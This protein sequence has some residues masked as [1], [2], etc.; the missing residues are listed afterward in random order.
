[1][2]RLLPLLLCAGAACAAADTPGPTYAG[3]QLQ[4][5][6]DYREWIWLTSGFDMSY[7]PS[8]LSMGHHMFD[9]V[10]VD[11]AAW[12]AFQKTGAWPDKAMLL[13]EGR[14]AVGKASI[15]RAGQH[16][17][18]VMVWELHVKDEARFPDK[19]GFFAT[20]EAGKPMERIPSSAECYSCHRDHGAVDTTFVQFY[21]TMLP[22]AKAMG[23][24]SASYLQDVAQEK[25]AAQ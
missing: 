12:A 8:L 20:G 21:P 15:N 3:E 6:A 18:E 7:N 1:M 17:G 19:W 9:N 25:P 4:F 24:L 13:I 23:T 14:G 16:Q 10:F 22:L 11:R 5:P 2:R